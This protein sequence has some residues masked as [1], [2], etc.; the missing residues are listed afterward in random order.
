MPSKQLK[1]KLRN[2]HKVLI[3]TALVV[4]SFSACKK[5]EGVG[6]TSTIKGRVLVNDFDASF[7][8]LA[9][10]Y[11]LVDKNVYIIYGEDHTTYNDNYNSSYDGSYEFKFLQK[12]KYKIFAYSKDST[13]AAAGNYNSNNPKIAKF[14]EVEITANGS[15]ITAPDIIILD[16]NY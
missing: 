3:A 7:Q 12:G 4:V 9:A 10:T 15:T 14:A 11:P 6:G 8:S 16:N 13:G 2:I 1:M 5:D